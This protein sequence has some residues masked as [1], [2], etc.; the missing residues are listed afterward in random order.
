MITLVPGNLRVISALIKVPFV[1]MWLA[2]LD[3]DVPDVSK[4]PTSGKLTLT[5]STNGS[6][7]TLVGTIESPRVGPLCEPVPHASRQ[8]RWRVGQADDEAVLARG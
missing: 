7:T 1:G 8:R 6:T 5:I 4:V 3:L 2:Y